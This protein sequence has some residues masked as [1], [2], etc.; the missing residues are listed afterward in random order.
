[1]P[2]KSIVDLYAE[3]RA[4]TRLVDLAPRI[5]SDMPKMTVHPDLVVIHDARNH[6]R[7][8]YYAQTLVMSEHHGAHVDAPIHVHPE[9][10]DATIENVDVDQMM[11]PYKKYDLGRLDPQPGQLI[12]RSELREEEERA[13]FSL[14]AGDIALVDFGWSRFYVPDEPDWEKRRY[15]ADFNAGLAEDACDY[16]AGRGIKAICSDTVACDLSLVE[17]EVLTEFGHRTYFLPN[18]ILIGEG[19][20]NLAEIPATGLLIAMPLRIR[21]GSGSPLRPVAMFEPS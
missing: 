10:V 11:G 13:G 5:E 19:F 2:E 20:Q 12:T 17:G 8:G 21:D 7:H 18:G 1:M 3:L 15:W 6:E 4:R 16:L 9:M 14:E